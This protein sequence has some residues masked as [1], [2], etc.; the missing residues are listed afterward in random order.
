MSPSES[1]KLANLQST[2]IKIPQIKK[3]SSIL[4]GVWGGGE[5]LDLET[6][7]AQ[8]LEFGLGRGGHASLFGDLTQ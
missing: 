8:S 7:N 5:I 4:V 1:E 3:T 6:R 2:F